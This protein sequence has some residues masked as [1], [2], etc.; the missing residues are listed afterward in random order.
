[1]QPGDIS[2]AFIMK[3]PKKNRD[4]VAIV[5]LK[6]RVPGHRATLADDFNMI[7]QMYENHAK[8]KVLTEWVEQKIQNTYTRI[9]EGWDNCEFNYKG[10]VK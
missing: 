10:W 7:K 5:R 8:Q 4:V 6:E 2:E 9:S 1:M 3:D